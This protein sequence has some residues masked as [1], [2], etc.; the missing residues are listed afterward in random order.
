MKNRLR[1]TPAWCYLYPGS[2]GLMVCDDFAF[3]AFGGG[4]H[5]IPSGFWYNGAS[6]PSAFWQLIY[7]P[8]DPRVLEAA[9]IH[10]W[11]YTVKT[12]PREIADKTLRMHIEINSKDRI[13]P[14]LVRAAVGLCG[15]FA[16]KDSPADRMYI[17]RLRDEITK[18]GRRP[19]AYGLN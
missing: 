14:E 16:W 5:T 10:D 7:S 17:D 19:Y 18:T 4:I 9:C 3:M 1:L 8:F 6:I 2:P 11:L 13:K 12:L 15:G